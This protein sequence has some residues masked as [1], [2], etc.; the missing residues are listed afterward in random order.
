MQVGLVDDGTCYG[1]AAAHA[2]GEL[3]GELG[4]GLGELDEVEDFFDALVRLVGGDSF[5]VE[6]VGDVVFDVEGVEEGGLLED[7]ADA[8]TKLETVDLAH[9]D[10]V[11]AED[12]DGTG[13][14]L[15]EAIDELEQDGFA[16]AR[17]AEDDELLAGV[18]AEGDVFEDGFVVEFN[19]DVF[20]L[21]DGACGLG[22]G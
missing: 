12:L 19:G 2:S 1:D 21:D 17:G 18:D 20:E 16:A 14:G 11:L 4:D 22:H 3:G 10:D 15:D 13:V 6:A 5:L 7:H 9:G 8:V